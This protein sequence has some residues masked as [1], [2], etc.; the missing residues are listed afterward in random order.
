[1]I[2]YRAKCCGDLVKSGLSFFFA[3]D[4][5]C[6]DHCQK[7]YNKKRVGAT[8]VTNAL[9]VFLRV[10][11][12]VFHYCLMNPTVLGSAQDRQRPCVARCRKLRLGPWP[13]RCVVDGCFLDLVWPLIS[14]LVW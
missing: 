11:F 5:G 14:V 12:M 6:Q 7:H 1:M 2:P 3:G 9:I 8:G 10:N 13:P 4:G